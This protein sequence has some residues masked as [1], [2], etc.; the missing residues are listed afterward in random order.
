[1]HCISLFSALTIILRFHF[2]SLKFTISL[3][4]VITHTSC[5][6]VCSDGATEAEL[7]ELKSKLAK[8][9]K[10]EF[11][12]VHAMLSNLIQVTATEAMVQSSEADSG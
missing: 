8:M 6:A 7:D 10:S 2:K 9:K 3:V 4:V 5:G 12:L 11:K 1:M